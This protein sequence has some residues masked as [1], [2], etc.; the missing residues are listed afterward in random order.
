MLL[1]FAYL[2]FLAVLRLLASGR[3]SEFAKDVELLVL[4][5]QLAVL[6]TAAAASFA[7]ACRSRLPCGADASPAAGAAARLDRDA[8]ALLCWHQ[9][10]VRRKWTQPRPSPGR[11]AVDDRTRQLVQRFAR[12]N[13]GWGYPRIAGEPTGC[14]GSSA[15]PHP[16]GVLALVARAG[17]ADSPD[18]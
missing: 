16:V 10:L 13:P 11:P 12:E 15:A 18:V 5:H 3:R 7:P 4:R 6:G 14:S 9:E 2:A 1:S 17:G 8:T